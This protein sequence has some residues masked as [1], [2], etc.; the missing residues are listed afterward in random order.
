MAKAALKEKE[1]LFAG[2]LNLNLRRK[3]VKCYI[4][5]IVLY[6]VETRTP[7]ATDQKYLENFEM[8]CS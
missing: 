7:G 4:W 3:L 6:V 8:W 5:T 2:T 1:T